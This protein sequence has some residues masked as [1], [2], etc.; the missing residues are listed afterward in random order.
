M[1]EDEKYIQ[2]IAN[3]DDWVAIRKMKITETTGA[4]AVLEFLASLGSGF[5]RKIAQNL[6]KIIDVVQL[7][8]ALNDVLVDSAGKSAE[9]LGKIIALVRGPK[10][11]KVIS[12]LV[13]K[14]PNLES[15]VQKEIEQFAKAYAMRKALRECGLQVDYSEIEIP[16]MKKIKRAKA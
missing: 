13:G 2:F 14:V 16:G 5:D 1:G 11:N 4:K 10:I 9:E 3:Y 6:G 8:N 7:D 15:G 12:E